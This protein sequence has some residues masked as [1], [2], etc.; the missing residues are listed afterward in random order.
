MAGGTIY[1]WSNGFQY[2]EP[3]HCT[4][5][6][7]AVSNP[8]PI[9]RIGTVTPGDVPG[10]NFIG[11]EFDPIVPFQPIVILE[12]DEKIIGSVTVRRVIYFNGIDPLPVIQTFY[13]KTP[14]ERKQ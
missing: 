2:F 7:P 11:A 13:I 8:T 12:Q 14:I 6:T 5:L 3:F 1:T 10:Q 4:I 9:E